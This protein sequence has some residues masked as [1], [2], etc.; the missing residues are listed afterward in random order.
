MPDSKFWERKFSL[1][2][3]FADCRKQRKN[4]KNKTDN[5]W[6]PQGITEIIQ[7][8]L[9]KCNNKNRTE[10]HNAQFR[11][12]TTNLTSCWLN[13]VG[14]FST[15]FSCIEL[16]PDSFATLFVGTLA[17]VTSGLNC[18]CRVAYYV[19]WRVSHTL[20]WNVL[21]ELLIMPTMNVELFSMRLK[22]LSSGTE[23]VKLL[24]TFR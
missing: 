16:W 19:G 21:V 14:A 12:E 17:S 10:T 23:L 15:K 1:G 22:R 9:I 4:S 5:N 3:V 8:W 2:L 24:H 13:G 20:L 6:A 7:I 18:A 11:K